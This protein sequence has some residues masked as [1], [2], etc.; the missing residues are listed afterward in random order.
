MTFF[1]T[2]RILICFLTS[3]TFYY[4][5]TSESNFKENIPTERTQSRFI[6]TSFFSKTLNRD[7]NYTI[8]LPPS[9]FKS[10]SSKFE[11]LYLLHGHG[12]NEN[13]WMAENDLRNS[14][15]SLITKDHLKEFVIAMPDGGNSWYVNGVEPIEDAFINDFRSEINSN[16]RIHNGFSYQTIGGMS[17]GGYGSLR[18]ILKYPE[19]FKNALLMSPAAYTPTPDLN[20]FARFDVPSFK[21]VNNEFSDSIWKSYNY[22]NYWTLFDKSKQH[23]LFYLSTGTSDC[24]KGIIQAV[25]KTLPRELS[26]RKKNVTFSIAN[27]EG[28]HEMK[29]WKQALLDA[30]KIIY[31]K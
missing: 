5:C 12:G 2:N 24:Y 13:A 30:L 18:F 31:K 28:G 17:A 25:N 7:W 3:L 20:S 16:Y 15:D 14:I 6:H 21:N 19:K 11:I 8:Y 9:Y 29:V 10:K 23:H 4:S 26:K 22:P 27:Y 1:R